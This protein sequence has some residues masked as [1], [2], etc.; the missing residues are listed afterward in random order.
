MAV[1]EVVDE[2]GEDDP[3]AASARADV[4]IARTQT[5]AL[6]LI[7]CTASDSEQ[8]PMGNSGPCN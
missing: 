3:H 5:A 4:T 2:V 8:V 1:V 7:C 6:L